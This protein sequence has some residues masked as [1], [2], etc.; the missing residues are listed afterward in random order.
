MSSSSRSAR[1]AKKPKAS[2]GSSAT[3]TP[4]LVSALQHL[5]GTGGDRRT[6]VRAFGRDAAGQRQH[7]ERLEGGGGRGN[8][9]EPQARLGEAAD[10]A[11]HESA[12]PGQA[13][14]GELDLL[15]KIAAG[16]KPERKGVQAGPW[17]ARSAIRIA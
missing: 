8:V 15:A 9:G 14:G 5:A 10:A 6:Q 11:E 1:H 16:G 13:A 17:E 7:F 2:T 4:A 12:L 3:G